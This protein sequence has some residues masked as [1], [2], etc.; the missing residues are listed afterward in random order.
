MNYQFGIASWVLL[1]SASLSFMIGALIWRQFKSSEARYLV[2]LEFCCALWAFTIAFESA[3]ITLSGKFI[4][5]VIAYPSTVFCAP[6]LFLFAY[7]YAHRGKTTPRALGR[8]LAIIPIATIVMAATNPWHGLVWP[9]ITIDPLTHIATYQHGPWFWV[10]VMYS[11]GLL[12]AGMALL[13]GV[14]FRYPIFYRAQI[15]AVLAAI[16][17]GVSGSLIYL[18]GN[19][20]IAGLD[21]T[22]IALSGSTALIA[23]GV[24]GLRLFRLVPMAHTHLVESMSDAVLVLD[25]D[26]LLVDANP[27]AL[28][29]A[30]R[31]LR[32]ALGLAVREVL[33]LSQSSVEAVMAAE[34]DDKEIEIALG[35]PERPG[36]YDV[37]VSPL[38]DTGGALLGRLLVLRDVTPRRE[39][40]REREMLIAELRQALTEVK[41]LSG[42]LP[43]CANCKKIRDDTGYWHGV[44][45]YLT[46]HSGA[47]FI[48]GLCPDC[49]A[50][51]DGLQGDE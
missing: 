20:P 12:I 27:P 10:F 28:A 22:P 49:Q 31:E 2:W 43:I 18:T 39:I 5:S 25:A 8:A 42:L 30:G 13:A 51:V 7:T 15:A 21:T 6:L 23:L 33:P 35:P 37:R 14:M 17:V 48:Q 32:D 47:E 41:T 3:V 1:L 29:L 24:F 34:S 11:Y 4:W 19:S 16:L 26:G 45:I 44:D 38:R 40:E 9:E 36:H 50:E 46:K